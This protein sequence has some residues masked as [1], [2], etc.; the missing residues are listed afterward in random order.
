MISAKVTSASTASSRLNGNG[1]HYGGHGAHHQHSSR[2]EDYISW[3]LFFLKKKKDFFSRK[4][5]S[6]GLNERIRKKNYNDY[7]LKS[8][9]QFAVYLLHKYY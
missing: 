8:E 9:I 2:L 5:V 3:W 4:K 6:R 1:G 7:D